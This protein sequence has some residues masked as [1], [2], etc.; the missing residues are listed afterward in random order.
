MRI[1]Q[2]RRL[3]AEGL[4]PC[5]GPATDV[6]ALKKRLWAL[7][8]EFAAEALSDQLTDAAKEAWSPMAFLDALIRY[9]LERR[10]ERRVRLAL[11][12][13][14]IPSGQTLSN[15]DFAFQPAVERSRVETL[16]TCGWIRE[17][18]TLL[19]QGPP[20]VGKTHLAVA[21]G[22]KAIETGFSVCFYRLDDLLH[23]MK[24]QGDVPAER[25]KYKK[26]MASNLLIIDEMGFQT[27]T[28]EEANLFFRLVNYRYQRGAIC[29]TTNKSIQ[30]WP[31]FLAGDEVLATAIL[32]RLLHA[33][34]V[35]NVRGRSYRLKELD[36]TL[37]A[38]CTTKKKRP[39]E[40]EEADPP[41]ASA[42]PVPVS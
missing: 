14:G 5:P 35:F 8:W 3:L 16:A 13:S 41:P 26:Y 19:I 18:Y 28:R 20:G 2:T 22:V 12:I 11:K 25:L 32:D 31:E 33:S 30:D 9:E 40:G 6:D 36:E 10:E 21:L 39:S 37:R 34:H 23:T 15:F 38:Q 7:E 4:L 1:D 29:L 42:A 27:L 17:Q 24:K